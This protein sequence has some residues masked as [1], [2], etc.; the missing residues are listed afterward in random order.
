MNPHRTALLAVG[1]LIYAGVVLAMLT[2]ASEFDLTSIS[3]VIGGPIYATVGIVILVNRPGHRIGRLLLILGI[4]LTI[5]VVGP[6]LLEVLA[7][8]RWAI[9]PLR[10]VLEFLVEWSGSIALLIGT[11]L[12]LVWFPDG[13][14]TSR[15]GRFIEVS[16]IV[17]VIGSV[18]SS[19]RS[20]SD[21]AN[22]VVFLAAITLYLLAIIEL[23]IRTARA[24]PRE[25]AAMRWVFASAAIVS[26]FMVGVMTI[27]NSLPFLWNLWIN[28]TILPA[29]AVAIAIS[30]HHLYD[31]DRFISRTIAYSLVTV[32]LFAVFAVVNV[33]LQTALG[34]LVLDNAIAVAV[35]T[36]VVATLFQPLR[37]RLQRVVDRRFDRGRYDANRT[38]ED[39]ATRLRDELDLITLTTDLQRVTAS[40]V[41][42]VKAG[43]WLRGRH[44]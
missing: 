17:F 18:A 44:P 14:A 25:Q 11:I 9:R 1:V 27:G 39:Y 38:V 8:F 33:S 28:A 15:L 43:V 35:S 4:G 16:S 40:A 37:T 24:A 13:R 29:I 21:L 20:G 30:R 32:I 5:T 34:S 6:L 7:P 2:D 19:L 12:V 31:I 36:L 3:F 23:G 42:P 41:Q 22:T 10:V 26:V